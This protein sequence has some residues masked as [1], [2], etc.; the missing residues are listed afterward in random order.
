MNRYMMLLAGFAL[1]GC[2][3]SDDLDGGLYDDGGHLIDRRDADTSKED[4]GHLIDIDGSVTGDASL[5]FKLTYGKNP[6]VQFPSDWASIIATSYS[7]GD[8]QIA[9]ML[10]KLSDPTCKSPVV[11]R[12][13]TSD[14]RATDPNPIQ[15]MF[16]PTLTVSHLPEGQF[17]LM[18]IEDASASIARGFGFDDAFE[19]REK[20]WDG[21]VSEF[22]RMLTAEGDEPTADHIPEPACHQITLKSNQTTDLGTLELGHFHQRDISPVL[23]AEPGVIA[24][25][26]EEGLKI[27]DLQTKALV[28]FENGSDSAPITDAG[29]NPINGHICGTVR[30]EGHTLY[31]IYKL[32]SGGVVVPYDPLLRTQGSDPMILLP[33]LS[34]EERCSGA[35]INE[36]N[37]RFLYVNA[38]NGLWYAPLDGSDPSIT[39]EALSLE[40]GLLFGG[41]FRQAIPYG[42]KLLLIPS[43]RVDANLC[44]ENQTCAFLLDR[45][46]GGRPVTEDYLRFKTAP[47]TT[48]SDGVQAQSHAQMRRGGSIARFH[49]G[50]DLLF[51]S[52]VLEIAVFNLSSG[53]QVVC[54]SQSV[55]KGIE[56]AYLGQSFSQF[57][58]SPDG[59][60]LWAASDHPSPAMLYAEKDLDP[61]SRSA[62]SR[63]LFLPIDLS[64]G[65]VP[66]IAAAYRSRDLDQ[67]E[68]LPANAASNSVPTP[69]IDPGLDANAF[70]FKQYLLHWLGSLVGSLPNP[71]P[72]LPSI[73][74]TSSALWMIGEG[75]NGSSGLGQ[76]SNLAAFDLDTGKAVLF[77]RGEAFYRPWTGGNASSFGFDLTPDT[78]AEIAVYSIDYVSP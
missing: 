48:S 11:S 22:D 21:K 41:G 59:K 2:E 62:Q 28:T 17:N 74:V 65:D 34:L 55:N 43:P 3:L 13:L 77:P 9:I 75:S 71:E 36:E 49:N 57:T 54:N 53:E 56:H 76:L 7:K 66:A 18:V 27:V 37:E 15:F 70:W 26:T 24:V 44:E 16:G 38:S 40:D 68:G 67:F 64:T 5:K 25:G 47:A 12:K 73:A 39:A 52:D 30:G 10:C 42:S 8:G 1:L 6:S 19:T 50:D 69:K 60:T 58:L 14:E 78:N 51:L 63:R 31:L 29:G 32:Q 23:K 72:T 46:S 35:F 45:D 4:G 61:E 20:D 33:G